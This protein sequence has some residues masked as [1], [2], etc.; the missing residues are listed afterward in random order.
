VVSAVPVEL[1]T[2]T[3]LPSQRATF[4]VQMMRW[5]LRTSVQVLEQLTLPVSPSAQAAPFRSLRSHSSVP[6]ATPSPQLVPQSAGQLVV[7]SPAAAEQTVSPQLALVQVL[8][9]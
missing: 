2:K 3:A 5:Q 1:Q 7:L 4:G 6:L 8:T 9:V